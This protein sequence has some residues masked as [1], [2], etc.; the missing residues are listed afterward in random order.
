MQKNA[1]KCKRVSK[2][3]KRKNLSIVKGGEPRVPLGFARRGPKWEL[4]V[5][6]PAVFVRVANEGVGGYGTWKSVRRMGDVAATGTQRQR[7][8]REVKSGER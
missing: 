2:S 6:T 1:K 8:R 7:A 3:L 4:L 5:H